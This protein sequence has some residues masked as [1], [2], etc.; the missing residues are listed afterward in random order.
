VSPLPKP[1]EKRTGKS[2]PARRVPPPSVL[3]DV[4]LIDG[5]NAAAAGCMGLTQWHELV[6]T[7]IA[8]QPVIKQPRF[9]RWRLVDVRAWLEKSSAAGSL[10]GAPK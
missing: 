10:G 3:A 5:P 1:V 9:T 2:R 7:G 8:P 4:A 6:K